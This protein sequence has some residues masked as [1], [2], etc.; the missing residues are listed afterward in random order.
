MSVQNDIFISYA[1]LDN[2]PALK[3]QDGW[4]SS[5]HRALEVRVGQL[6]GRAPRIWRDP[7]LDGNDVFSDA[8]VSQLPEVAVLVTVLSPRYLKSEWC[9]KQV[10]TFWQGCGATGGTVIG[11]KSRVL[12]V[13][14]TPVADD[15]DPPE[16]KLIFQPLL[17]D[18]F[19][20]LERA[21]GRAREFD[22]AFGQEALAEYWRRLDDLAQDI[23]A[24]LVKMH[25]EDTPPKG[26]VYVAP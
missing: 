15:D 11:T 2:E 14:K 8:I 1:H 7:K 9:R 18:P 6:L 16:L 22:P 13:I 4:I 21:T 10:A 24:L 12:K 26:T 25:L 19:F 5:F 3:G 20:K 17:G 23:A